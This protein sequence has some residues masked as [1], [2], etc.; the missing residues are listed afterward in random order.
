[1]GFAPVWQVLSFVALSF[2]PNHSISN[3]LKSTIG[4]ETQNS[5]FNVFLCVLCWSL[6]MPYTTLGS[7]TL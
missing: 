5:C 4:I 7:T 2:M 3:S 1:V 6:S